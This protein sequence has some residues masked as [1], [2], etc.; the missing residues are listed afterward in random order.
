MVISTKITSDT[1]SPVLDSP[2]PPPPPAFFLDAMPNLRDAPR[3]AR[4]GEPLGRDAQTPAR[5]PAPSE[6]YL[7]G[8][9]LGRPVNGIGRGRPAGR[10]RRTG[11]AGCAIAPRPGAPPSCRGVPHTPR[12]ATR[13]SGASRPL[14]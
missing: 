14:R 2:P 12:R 4:F 10:T 11:G 8:K 7:H 5:A 3:A 6:M 13:T 9:P 1:I